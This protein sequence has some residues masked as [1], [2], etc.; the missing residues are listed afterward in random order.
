[1]KVDG[2]DIKAISEFDI[3]IDFG[4]NTSTMTKSV[5][6]TIKPTKLPP[7]VLAIEDHETLQ[8]VIGG[9]TRAVQMLKGEDDGTNET[10]KH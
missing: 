7:I 9:L 5:L 8:N 6:V 4:Y 3:K 10:T 1:M 2:K